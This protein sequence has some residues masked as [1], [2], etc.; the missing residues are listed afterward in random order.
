MV[1]LFKLINS[2]LVSQNPNHDL[3][4]AN[5]SYKAQL[6]CRRF[7]LFALPLLICLHGLAQSSFDAV[8]QLLK[9]NQKA[10]G[11]GYVML[12]W[13]DGK[14]VYQK[15]ANP[16]FTAKSPAPIAGAGNWMTAALVMTF[17]D[18]GKLSLDDKV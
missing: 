9:Q 12:V 15:Q 3:N 7:S 8:D 18:E 17:V 11:G 5:M 2:K 4:P 13:K 10:F 6:T 1:F 16:D 14:V